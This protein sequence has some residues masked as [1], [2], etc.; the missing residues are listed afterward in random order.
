MY[1]FSQY[2]IAFGAICGIAAWFLFQK[3]FHILIQ[4]LENNHKHTWGYLGLQNVKSHPHNAIMNAKF[5]QYVINKKYEESSDL[6]V[7]NMGR[8]IRQR[9]LFILLC[10]FCLISGLVLMLFA[11]QANN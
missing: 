1:V 6:F 10:L 11:M 9:L 8:L 7:K 3:S 5:R 4:H 2:L